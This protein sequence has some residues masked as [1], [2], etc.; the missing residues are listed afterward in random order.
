MQSNFTCSFS[1]DFDIPGISNARRR[2]QVDGMYAYSRIQANHVCIMEQYYIH[3]GQYLVQ[4]GHCL[5]SLHTYIC[6]YVTIYQ[7]WWTFM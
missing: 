4:G 1:E 6:T 3:K 2:R 5:T 7:C